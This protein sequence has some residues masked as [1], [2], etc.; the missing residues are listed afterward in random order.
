MWNL[1]GRTARAACLIVVGLALTG[2]GSGGPAPAGDTGAA[3]STGA[4]PSPSGP[5]PAPAELTDAYFAVGQ[6]AGPILGKSRGGSGPPYQPVDCGDVFAVAKVTRRSTTTASGAPA[7]RTP[8][9]E[10][11]T[12]L[13]LDLG[14]NLLQAA[15]AESV[16]GRQ[17]AYA[18]LRNLKDPHPGD[19]GMGGGFKI[20]V[21]DC[22]YQARTTSGSPA[23]RET[24]CDGTGTNPPEYRV[25]KEY[26]PNMAKSGE[27]EGCPETATVQF[28]LSTSTKVDL[29][30]PVAC[31]EKL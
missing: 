15:G 4:S 19:P 31:A 27:H 5:P 21:G 24:R 16:R 23:V 29:F 18:C 8:E 17:E 12:D 7:A 20:V 11:T 2:C 25:V 6:C 10:D 14:P 22:V 26:V 3:A 30:A 13:V 28:S 1:R 9:C